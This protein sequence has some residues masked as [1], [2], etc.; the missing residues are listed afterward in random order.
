[1]SDPN[2]PNL[3][4]YLNRCRTPEGG[5]CYFRDP[6]SGAGFPNV[7]DTYWALSAFRFLE[8]DPP[9]LSL[10][11]TW[12]RNEFEQNEGAHISP[13]SFLDHGRASPCRGR[14]FDQRSSLSCKGNRKTFK[15]LDDSVGPSLSSRGSR[16]RIVPT[17]GS[18][19]PSFRK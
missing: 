18:G 5:Y 14:Y 4:R 8:S 10:T 6:E 13:L 19:S 1:M 3:F 2:R 15:R 17:K 7:A 9:F 16:S 11:R 12:L